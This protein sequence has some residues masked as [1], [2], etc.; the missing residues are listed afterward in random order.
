MYSANA[1]RNDSEQWVITVEQNGK[2]IHRFPAKF[3]SEI[4]ELLDGG[5]LGVILGQ[6]P[7][8]MFE[9]VVDALADAGSYAAQEFKMENGL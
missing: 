4:P 3:E 8:S 1:T 7:E 9:A 6:V 2:E 5:M